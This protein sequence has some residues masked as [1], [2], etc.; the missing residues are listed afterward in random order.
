MILGGKA[1]PVQS[2]EVGPMARNAKVL[3]LT[4][5]A[6]IVAGL[7]SMSVAFACTPTARV[8]LSSAIGTPGSEVQVTGEA[9]KATGPAEIWW[10]AQSERRLLATASV[11]ERGTFTT[12]PPLTVP[13]DA[14]AGPH[15]IRVIVDTGDGL[16]SRESVFKVMNTLVEAGP[17]AGIAAGRGTLEAFTVPGVEAFAS[18]ATSPTSSPLN[19][20]SWALVGVALIL[21]AGA[22]VVVTLQRIPSRTAS[23]G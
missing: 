15:L 8:S 1:V 13:P 19:L 18:T 17:V 2:G 10:V 3:G 6:V 21:A 14:A 16:A 7:L 5:L 4:G 12:N 9:F 22:A 23:K 11:D 20:A